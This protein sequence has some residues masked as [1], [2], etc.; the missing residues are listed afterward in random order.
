[1]TGRT[2]RTYLFSSL[3][4]KKIQADFDGGPPTSDAG[5]LLLLEQVDQRLLLIGSMADRLHDPRLPSLNPDRCGSFE[6]SDPD[7]KI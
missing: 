1:M 7:S 4:E 5:V 6:F 3:G 2:Q